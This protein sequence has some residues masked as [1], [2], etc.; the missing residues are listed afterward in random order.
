MVSRALACG[1]GANPPNPPFAKG[2]LFVVRRLFFSPTYRHSRPCRH[3]GPHLFVI[4]A[5][6]G[7]H[8][9][10]ASSPPL[11]PHRHSGAGRNPEPRSASSVR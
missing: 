11:H 8:T 7:I 3:S 9:P 5:K 1:G 10:S 2:G 4:P 6:A